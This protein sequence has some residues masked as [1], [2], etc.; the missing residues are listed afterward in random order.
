MTFLGRDRFLG[1]PTAATLEEPG[2]ERGVQLLDKN[3]APSAAT[4]KRK[5]PLLK[6]FHFSERFCLE[7]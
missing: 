1:K 4:G 3:N 6:E 7:F 5:N 2:L